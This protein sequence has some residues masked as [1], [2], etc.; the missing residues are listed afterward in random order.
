MDTIVHNWEIGCSGDLL[1]ERIRKT[2][3]P[4]LFFAEYTNKLWAAFYS[5]K[6]EERITSLLKLS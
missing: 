1:A 5:F 3:V 2:K 6:V 4:S